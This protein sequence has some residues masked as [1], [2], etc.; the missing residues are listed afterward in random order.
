MKKALLLLPLLLLLAAPVMAGPD[1]AAALKQMLTQR[2][3]ESVESRDRLRVERVPDLEVTEKAGQYRIRIPK[4]RLAAAD[5]WMVEAPLVDGEGMPRPDGSW[6]LNLRLPQ[7]VTLYGGAGFRLGDVALARQNLSVTVS[8]DGRTLLAADLDMGEGTFTPALGAGTGSLTALRLILAPKAT[9]K[10]PAAAGKWSGRASL[11][12]DGLFLKDPMGVDR[13][14]VQRLRLEGTADALD[15]ARMGEFLAQGDRTRLDR[16]ARSITLSA[17]MAGL[18][19]VRDDGTRS[20]LR[21]GNGTLT[22]TGLSGPRTDLSLRWTHEGLDH[23]GPGLAP[24]LLPVAADMAL[25][26]TALPPALLTGVKPADGWTPALAASGSSLT[27]SR[28]SLTS[29]QAVMLG[30]GG[31]RFDKTAANNVTGNANMSLRGFDSIITDI[32]RSLGAR[33]AGLVIGLYALQGLGRA[34]PGPQGTTH[35]YTLTLTPQGQIT[36]NG[37]DATGLFRGLLTLK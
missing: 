34:E 12:I 16:L 6:R 13:L 32:N 37:T 20:A 17:D 26:G 3:S 5:G 9:Q 2:L 4:L 33:G 29:P 23:T 15:M 19:Q 36:L 24:G 11:A 27:L 18:R 22:L 10:S 28:L 31:V 14:A 8:A 1:Q 21:A 25:T 35:H 30:Q 7:G